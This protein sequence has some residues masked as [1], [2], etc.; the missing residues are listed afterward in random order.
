MCINAFLEE[1]LLIMLTTGNYMR[2]L[3]NMLMHYDSRYVLN[4][5]NFQNSVSTK[6]GVSKKM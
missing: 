6:D 1:F 2:F 3:N 4:V 5:R